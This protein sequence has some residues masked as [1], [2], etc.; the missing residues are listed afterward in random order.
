MLE[1]GQLR[2]PHKTKDETLSRQM[3]N[4]Q[5]VRY[6]AKTGEAT[7]TSVDDHAL[8][9]LMFCLYGFIT[10]KPEL[11]NTV[12]ERPMATS[13]VTVKKKRV[14]PFKQSEK[15]SISDK[16]SELQKEVNKVRRRTKRQ[17][18]SFSWGSRGSGGNS[19]PTRR[20]W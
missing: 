6:S 16:D 11:A 1:R 8:D 15:S 18:S 17:R 9:A 10:E 12:I 3:T 4:Y 7:Y 19:M 14:D 5:V 20:S 2:I 13:I